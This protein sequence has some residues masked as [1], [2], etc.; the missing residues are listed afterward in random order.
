M[1]SVE[2]YISPEI[3]ARLES[4]GIIELDYQPRSTGDSFGGI[5]RALH[6]ISTCDCAFISG[7]H[8][9][10]GGNDVE[11]RR[12]NRRNND[13]LQKALREKGY[14][15]IRAVG[16]YEGDLERSFC[17]F[18]RKKERDSLFYDVKALAEKF[19]QDSFLFKYASDR[20]AF[21]YYTYGPKKG[22]R[23]DAGELTMCPNYQSDYTKIGTGKFS[24]KRGPHL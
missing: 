13:E 24:F 6:W 21:F 10:S 15:V 1:N 5:N 19:E 9:V 3:I 4:L 2:L 18:D 23:E 14:G 8:P 16:N 20:Q 12:N 7:W 11:T 22:Q 17:V